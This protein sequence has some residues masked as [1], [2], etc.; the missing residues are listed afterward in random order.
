MK[1]NTSKSLL[2]TALLL[3]SCTVYASH[4]PFQMVIIAED[5][6]ATLIEQPDLATTMQRYTQTDK[7]DRFARTMNLCVA[8]SKQ[9]SWSQAMVACDQAVSATRHAKQ[10]SAEAQRQLRAYAYSNRGVAKSLSG[11]LDGALADFQRAEMLSDNQIARHNLTIL[12]L[13][14][15]APM[16]RVLTTDLTTE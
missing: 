5:P 12:S 6:L 7:A 15:Q 8:F 9:Q 1:L 16:A 2:T 10:A 14:Q 4:T 3:A 11:D 13:R